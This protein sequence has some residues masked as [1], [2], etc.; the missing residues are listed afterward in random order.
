MEK[1]ESRL[2]GWKKKTLLLA[3]RTILIKSVASSLP[4][5][6]MQTFLLPSS[7]CD[8]MD[9]LIRRF[10]WG[11]GDQQRGLYLRAWD[12]LCTPKL[13]GGLGLR[14]MKDINM[15]FV[16]KLGWNVCTQPSKTWVQLIRSKYLR[17]RKVTDFQH[18]IKS[19]SWIW[20]G[21]QKSRESLRRGLCIKLGRNSIA[22]IR[23]DPWL[24]RL[25]YCTLLADVLVNDQLF[26]VRDLMVPDGSCWNATTVSS[27]FPLT[28]RDLF[29]STPI[30]EEH[31]TF[32]W[33]PSTS[34]SFSVRNYYRVNN[35][36]RFSTSS[37]ID[38]KF[39]KHLWHSSLH[40]RHKILI[41]KLLVN[42][43]PTKE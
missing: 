14:S 5:Y 40:E 33:A 42:I 8:R 17:G 37:H 24:L 9:S 30:F 27:N 16:T 41:W 18:T 39:W 35:E 21:I 32:V 25:A 20:A 2:A 13:A 12:L 36:G 43:L 34:G 28:I 29:L 19:S 10:W 23:D 1:L 6:L 4:S 31:D 15:A 22:H 11:F 38:R 26:Y 7:L 3:G